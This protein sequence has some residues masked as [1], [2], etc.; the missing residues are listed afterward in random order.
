MPRSLTQKRNHLIRNYPKQGSDESVGSGDRSTEAL[1]SVSS[2][3]AR[4][5]WPDTPAGRA[6]R[7][8]AVFPAP[9]S[10]T[11]FR[12]GTLSLFSNGDCGAK[13]VSCVE[14]A[15]VQC[16]EPDLLKVIAEFLVGQVIELFFIHFF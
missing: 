13:G 15:V 10:S 16:S 5:D 6:G 7:R 14:L 9:F 4:E 1:A 3:L 12:R 11:R 8:E 2:D